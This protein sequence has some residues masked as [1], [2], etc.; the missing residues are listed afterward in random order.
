VGCAVRKDGAVL[1]ALVSLVEGA[2]VPLVG[3]G[4]LFL[5][6]ALAG[7]SRGEDGVGVNGGVT[8]GDGVG[9]G[10]DMDVNVGYETGEKV[11]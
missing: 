7:G 6:S 2:I 5:D 4:V 1:G 8:V 9:V 10:D 3:V 11:N